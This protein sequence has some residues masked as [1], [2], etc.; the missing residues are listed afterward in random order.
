M[1]IKLNKKELKLLKNKLKSHIN[2]YKQDMEFF[3]DLGAEKEIKKEI[4]ILNKILE[5]L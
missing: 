3:E 4:K 2:A 5:K 1:K